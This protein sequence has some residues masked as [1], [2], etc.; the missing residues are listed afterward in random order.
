VAC[1]DALRV[2]EDSARADTL[3]EAME[4]DPSQMQ[5]VFTYLPESLKSD[6]LSEHFTVDCVTHFQDLDQAGVG[7]LGPEELYPVIITLSNS[8]EASLDLGQCQRFAAIF[9][10][11]RKGV[12]SADAF[13]DFARFLIIMAWLQ[14]HEG[15]EVYNMAFRDT[16]PR[17]PAR[18]TASEPLQA[19]PSP[20]DILAELMQESQQNAV[21]LGSFDWS[22][23]LSAPTAATPSPAGAAS[24]SRD[25]NLGLDAEP[26]DGDAFGSLSE[27]LAIL[28]IDV[29]GVDAY[30]EKSAKLSAENDHLRDRL[31]SLEDLIKSLEAR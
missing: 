8:H 26:A 19:D 2:I 21:D 23:P 27:N 11:E 6:L 7:S 20:A 4:R 5:M 18:A 12:I 1:K 29:A 15:Q 10:T 31:S 16:K 30:H 14:S 9:D 24:T 28:G 17:T 3:L 25:L 13:V 22:S